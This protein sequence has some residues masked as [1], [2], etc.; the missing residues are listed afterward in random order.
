[1]S[2]L[3]VEDDGALVWKWEGKDAL[4]EYQEWDD[5]YPE[6]DSYCTY[7]KGIKNWYNEPCDRRNLVM[8]E[9]RF[10]GK[11]CDNLQNHV[12]TYIHA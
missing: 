10:I 5:G 6:I 12:H 11:D 1:M 9:R 2:L 7:V 4:E 8:C 3:A